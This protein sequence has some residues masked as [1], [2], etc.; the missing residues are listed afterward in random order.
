MHYKV[1][2]F[3][4]TILWLHLSRPKS[5]AVRPVLLY[6]LVG[7]LL[8]ANVLVLDKCWS[9]D[10]GK[11]LDVPAQVV[12]ADAIVVLGGDVSLRLPP[13]VEL[14]HAGLVPEFWYTGASP[15]HLTETGAATFG[16]YQRAREV[17]IPAEAITLLATTSTWEDAEQIAATVQA[18]GTRSIL[19]VTSWYHGRRALCAIHHHLQDLDVSVYY[20]P[21][22]TPGFGA[23]DWWQS[24]RG[25]ETVTME[26]NK[27]IFYWSH[28]GLIPWV[29]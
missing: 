7:F 23:G 3:I 17:G 5:S 2:R 13:A 29:C 10:V 9:C 6:N 12:Q 20:Q 28:Y 15:A 26:L 22:A 11:W 1:F 25:K 21:V 16:A 8:V 19:V 27:I 14:F 24:E 4:R 18:R